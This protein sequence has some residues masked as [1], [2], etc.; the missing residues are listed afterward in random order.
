[1]QKLLNTLQKFKPAS[2]KV[3]RYRN[4]QNYF[5]NANGQTEFSIDNNVERGIWWGFII[6][7]IFM[8]QRKEG[9]KWS[10]YNWYFVSAELG[11]LKD[12]DLKMICNIYPLF[13]Q[14][15]QDIEPVP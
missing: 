14:E 2:I 9:A 11:T 1:M 15:V 3:A 6:V 5:G 12:H 8:P 13:G 7:S 4:S 10:K